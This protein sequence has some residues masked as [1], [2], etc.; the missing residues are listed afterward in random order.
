MWARL[1]PWAEMFIVLTQVNNRWANDRR[2]YVL[3]HTGVLR[4]YGALQPLSPA[5]CR[6]SAPPIA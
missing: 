2:L 3:V 1:V 5:F 4:D 6:E